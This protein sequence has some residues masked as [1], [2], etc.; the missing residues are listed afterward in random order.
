MPIRWSARRLTRSVVGAL[1]ALVLLARSDASGFGGP[2]ITVSLGLQH[3]LD[4]QPILF[5]DIGGAIC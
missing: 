2:K 1:C 5:A 4:V 3:S